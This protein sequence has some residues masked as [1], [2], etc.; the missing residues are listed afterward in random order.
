[1]EEPCGKGRCCAIEG[2]S[3]ILARKG[4]CHPTSSQEEMVCR[5]AHLVVVRPAGRFIHE[6]SGS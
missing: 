3:A 6:S 2:H 5:L 4:V 1:M